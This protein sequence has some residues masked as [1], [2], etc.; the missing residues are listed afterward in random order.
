MLNAMSESGFASID[1]VLARF[2]QLGY[3][4][5]T[6]VATCVFLADR[7]FVLSE[8]N[9]AEWDIVKIDLPTPRWQPE[10]RLHPNFVS[11]RERIYREMRKELHHDTAV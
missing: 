5:D 2:D 1:D 9:K 3:V 6:R 8:P 4:T 11:A 10:N 7:I